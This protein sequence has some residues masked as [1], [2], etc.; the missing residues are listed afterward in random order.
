MI[1]VYISA[2][3]IELCAHVDSDR[4]HHVSLIPCNCRTQRSHGPRYHRYLHWLVV[5]KYHQGKFHLVKTNNIRLKIQKVSPLHRYNYHHQ[6]KH[7]ATTTTYHYHIQPPHTSTTTQPPPHN[8]S[9]MSASGVF[10]P[11]D[12]RQNTTNRSC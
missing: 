10:A 9:C 12:G 2:A 7:T 3:V 11:V 8:A 5:Q 4:A 6:I 1:F